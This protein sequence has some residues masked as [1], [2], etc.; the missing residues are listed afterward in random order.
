MPALS[1]IALQATVVLLLAP[2]IKGI[3]RKA[4]ARLQ[5][6]QGAGALQPYYEL[7]KL[8]KKGSVVSGTTSWI[9][10]SAPYAAFAA[11]LVAGLIVPIFTTGLSLSLAGDFIALVYLFA[12]ARFFVALAA[13]DAGSSF[14]GMGSSREMTLSAL[15]E[16]A[17]LMSVFVVAISAGT[18]SLGVMSSHVA[19]MGLGDIPPAFAL[20]FVAF[21]IIAFAETGRIP[22]DNPATHL[23]LT[24]IHEA[25]IL[26]YSGKQLALIEWASSMKQLLIMALAINLFLPWGIATQGAGPAALA[27]SLLLFIAKLSILSALIAVIES[28]TA[29]WRLFR[30]PNLLI[31]SIVLSALALI[32]YYTGGV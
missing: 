17:L 32:S 7:V 31:L 9:F 4:K 13:L 18:T 28:S 20:A 15:A 12:L 29:K 24:M 23:E 16:P 26:E 25:M 22:F 8:M 19:G 2:L 3:N 6:R 21:M 1:S 14:G 10:A 5:G 11:M 27:M 30:V